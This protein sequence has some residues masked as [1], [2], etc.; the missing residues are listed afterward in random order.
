MEATVPLV[1]VEAMAL[2]A[3]MR[4]GMLLCLKHIFDCA[5]PGFYLALEIMKSC[6]CV[7]EERHSQPCVPDED[8]RSKGR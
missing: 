4:V 3:K 7:V 5:E 1:P 8:F 2:F 6:S